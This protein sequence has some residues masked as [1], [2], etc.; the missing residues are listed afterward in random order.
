MD[1][2]KGASFADA[3]VQLQMEVID[4]AE[5]LDAECGIEPLM[6]CICQAR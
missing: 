2:L 3:R 5:E 4:S 1:W 6:R